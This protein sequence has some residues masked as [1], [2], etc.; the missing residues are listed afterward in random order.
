MTVCTACGDPST[1]RD[2]FYYDWKGREYWIRRCRSCTHQFVDPPI[3]PD[4]QVEMYDDAYFAKDGDW[5]CGWFDGAS[6]EQATEHLVAEAAEILGLF[7]VRG[8]R[9]LDIGCAGGVFLNEARGAGFE[10]MG[11]E[12]NPRQAAAARE[13]YGLEVLNSRIEDAPDGIG[14]FDVVTLLDVLEHIPGPLDVIRRVAEWQRP[15]QF[16]LIRGPL[17]NS[18][19]AH[20]K[21]ALR[22]L[23]GIAKQLPGYPL[24]ANMFNRRSL[25]TMLRVGGYRV[26]KIWATFDFANV[27]AVRGD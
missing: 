9:L 19:I 22:R 8:G 6:Y 7:P 24:D 21:E 13:N 17:S 1:R 5:T 20:A 4:D 11:I 27:L 15:G 23:V 14:P 12:I 26:Q 18:R 2:P 16:L 25:E 3:S 10:V